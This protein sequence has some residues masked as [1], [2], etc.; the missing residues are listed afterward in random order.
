MILILVACGWWSLHICSSTKDVMGQNFI[1]WHYYQ[2]LWKSIELSVMETF[3]NRRDILWRAHPPETILSKLSSS[4]LAE[5]LRTWYI[6]RENMV[7]AE[8]NF[9]FSSIGSCQSIWFNRNIRSKLKQLFIYQDW[10][11]RSIVYI[12]DLLNP[13]HPGSKLFE[14]LVLDFNISPRDRRIFF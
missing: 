4:Q 11:D 5:S 12:S 6:V 14:E 10:M 9:S 1:R 8:F 7:K 3:N 2:S 13:P